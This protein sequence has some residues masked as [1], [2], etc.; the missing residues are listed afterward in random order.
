MQSSDESRLIEWT[1][2]HGLLM[3]AG[4]AAVLSGAPMI[5]AGLVA[6]LSFSAL[7]FACRNEWTP[8]GRFGV[9]NLVTALRFSMI[10]A[11]LCCPEASP[12]LQATVAGTV[13][14]L[15]G[16]DGWLARRYGECSSFGEFLDKEV[17]AF[18]TLALCLALY[19]SGRFGL[20]VLV[21]G[22]LRYAFVLFIRYARPPLPKEAATRFSRT[23]GAFLLG[24]L[25]V[26][27]LPI[28]PAGTWLAAAATAAVFTSFSGSVWHLYRR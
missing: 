6:L 22:G 19:Q 16:F 10:G 4:L 15:D 12:I 9:A 1:A 3:L 18:L 26:C 20:W 5:A 13:L 11:L 21:P 24:S 7:T 8:R 25:I 2:R 14:L 23:I 28:G 27:L 17:D